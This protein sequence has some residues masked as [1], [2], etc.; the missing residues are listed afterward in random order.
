MFLRDIYIWLPSIS[1]AFKSKINADPQRFLG[2]DVIVANDIDTLEAANEVY[3]L[4]ENKPI[5]VYDAHENWPYVRPFTPK[6]ISRFY[7]KTEAKMCKDCDAISSVSQLLVE[8]LRSRNG[9][10]KAYFYLPNAVPREQHVDHDIAK[11]YYKQR[12]ELAGER[13]VFVFQGGVAPERGLAEL[14]SAWSYVEKAVLFIRSPDG[15]NP[16]KEK[17]IEIAK[18]DGTYDR[19]VFFLP[20]IP[21]EHLISAASTADVGIIPYNPVFSN[22]IVAC[23]NKLS[24]YMHSGIAI[25][26]NKIPHVLS[27]LDKAGCGVS[28]SHEMAPEKIAE[29]ISNFAQLPELHTYGIKGK[30]FALSDYHW[31]NYYGDFCNFIVKDKVKYSGSSKI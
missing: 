4:N 23:P 15:R 26:S 2:Y 20:S 6:F 31:E 5:F 24:Q 7:A 8:D 21:E 27:V 25:L 19:S 17:I 3:R 11:I 14:I 18:K 10:D 9:S 12:E 16:E 28:Y 1:E 29:I 13:K 30:E 22:H